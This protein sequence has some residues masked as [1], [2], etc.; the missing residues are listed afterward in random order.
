ME[1]R[2]YYALLG[3]NRDDDADTIKRAYRKLARKYHPDRNPDPGAEAQFK[4]IGEAWAVLGNAEKRA[5]YDALG[6]G[7]QDHQR[8]EPPPGWARQF[9]FAEASGQPDD[10]ASLG[11]LFASLF[12]ARTNWSATR[13]RDAEVIAAITLEEAWRGE[14]V[15]IAT[16]PDMPPGTRTAAGTRD[17]HLR[18]QIPRGVHDGTRVRIRGHG[19]PDPAGGPPGDLFA[20]FRIAPHPQFHA[21]GSD[22]FCE[23]AVAPWECALGASVPVPTL[24]GPVRVRIAPNTSANT[25]LRLRGRG[26]PK[27]H[28]PPGAAPRGDQLVTLRVVLP[29]ATSDTARALYQ[30]MATEL[31]FDPRLPPERASAR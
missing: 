27:G 21:D 28:G 22:V 25:R 11:D 26:L 19:Y 5:A 23:L 6:A 29:E 14:R 17:R 30:R 2:D 12:G 18:V 8:F 4:A 13:G 16:P 9:R 7:W 3:V 20:V 15:T 24:G 31:A 1:Y 10:G